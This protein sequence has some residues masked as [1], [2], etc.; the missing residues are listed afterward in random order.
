M[1]NKSQGCC[2]IGYVHCDIQQGRT[3]GDWNTTIAGDS[4]LRQVA[5]IQS[6]NYTRNAKEVRDD[7]RYFSPGRGK[8]SFAM[9]YTLVN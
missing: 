9:G 1:Y 2:P 5:R 7:F 3:P 6:N 8:S 4:G